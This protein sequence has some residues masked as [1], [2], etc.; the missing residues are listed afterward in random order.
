MSRFFGSQQMVHT[1]FSLCLFQP[2]VKNRVIFSIIMQILKVC[3]ACCLDHTSLV[4]AAHVAGDLVDAFDVAV[5]DL[6][7]DARLE[8][9]PQKQAEG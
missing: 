2:W 5:D 8:A 9:R 7:G 4:K 1:S 6:E 3:N